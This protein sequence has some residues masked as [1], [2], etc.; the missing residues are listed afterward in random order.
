LDPYDSNNRDLFNELSQSAFQFILE[1][2]QTNTDSSYL[3]TSAK[4]HIL[5]HYFE[6]S[7]LRVPCST[8]RD[9][10]A[11]GDKPPEFTRRSWDDVFNGNGLSTRRRHV[12]QAGLREVVPDIWRRAEWQWLAP[13]SCWE[14]DRQA[15]ETWELL[16][17][18]AQ[19]KTDRDI[20]HLCRDGLKRNEVAEKLGIHLSTVQRRLRRIEIAFYTFND[21]K[22]SGA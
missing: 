6:D 1:L 10:V 8:Y 19:D 7:S 17:S 9:Y 2:A 3:F 5:K 4:R 22:I 14:E 21:W 16:L 18:F 12:Q 20:L 15:S 11:R 13:D